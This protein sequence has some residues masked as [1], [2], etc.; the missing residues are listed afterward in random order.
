MCVKRQKIII[1]VNE[2]VYYENQMLAN[3][4]NF[5]FKRFVNFA[6]NNFAVRACKFEI[7]VRSRSSQPSTFQIRIFKVGYKICTKQVAATW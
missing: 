4:D 2:R 1:N 5:C 6:L 7:T 3:V